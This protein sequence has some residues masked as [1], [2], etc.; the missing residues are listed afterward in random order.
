[1]GL[2]VFHS[3]TGGIGILTGPSGGYITGFLL[4]ALTY[5]I[6]IK[7]AGEK[8]FAKA[9][10]LVIGLIICYI[11]GSLQFALVTDI[12]FKAAVL[13]CVIPFILPD[14]AKLILSIL[15][16]VKLNKINRI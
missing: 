9:F 11:A 16:S 3:F 5:M 10:A 2:P 8:L 12:S 7:K 14:T 1:M 4:L 15:L 6:I 13:T